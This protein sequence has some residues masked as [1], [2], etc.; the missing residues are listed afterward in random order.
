LKNKTE[1]K[2]QQKKEKEKSFVQEFLR[3]NGTGVYGA[4][5]GRLFERAGKEVVFVMLRMIEFH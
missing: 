1:K 3:I 5:T 2:K 4:K